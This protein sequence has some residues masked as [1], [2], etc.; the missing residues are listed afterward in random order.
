MAYSNSWGIRACSVVWET[1]AQ[2]ASQSMGFPSQEYWSGLP[3]PPPGHLPYPEIEPVSLASAA[4]AGG[5]FT[6]G[7]PGKPIQVM[8]EKV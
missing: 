2:Q 8:V 5:F 3:Y 6:T 4:L 1:V 7:P